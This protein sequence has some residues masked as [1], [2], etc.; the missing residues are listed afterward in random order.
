MVA[1]P[2]KVHLENLQNAVPVFNREV[3]KCHRVLRGIKLDASVSSTFEGL[4]S[5]P[6]QLS[7]LFGAMT[8]EKSH[9]L[10]LSLEFVTLFLGL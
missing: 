9:V 4:P 5:I 10:T 2:E 1:C 3:I 7:A 8:S 6:L